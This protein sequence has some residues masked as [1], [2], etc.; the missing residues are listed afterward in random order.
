MNAFC[1]SEELDAFIVF[2]FSQPRKL[3]TENSNQ[4]RSNLTGADQQ[5]DL[6]R[7]KGHNPGREHSRR[8]FLGGKDQKTVFMDTFSCARPTSRL[9]DAQEA[10]RRCAAKQ[11]WRWPK[12]QRQLHRAVAGGVS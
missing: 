1:A 9:N 12:N 3:G 6:V 8:G 7:P 10:V 2:C 5:R 11:V 4:K